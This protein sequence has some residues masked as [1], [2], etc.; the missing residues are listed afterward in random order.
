MR[1]STGWFVPRAAVVTCTLYWRLSIWVVATT[2]MPAGS[3]NTG[4]AADARLSRT[5]GMPSVSARTTAAAKRT[6]PFLM[7]GLFGG[8]VPT[9]A[10]DGEVTGVQDEV[11]LLAQLAG[12][13]VEGL[14]V[15]LDD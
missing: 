13:G 15:H 5:A 10:R 9:P 4:A 6:R 3:T 7:N 2:W 14:A 1:M 12:K 11:V 8:A